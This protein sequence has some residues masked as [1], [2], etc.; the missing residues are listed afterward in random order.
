[1]LTL[2]GIILMFAAIAPSLMAGG[3]CIAAFMMGRGM[4]AWLLLTAGCMLALVVSGALALQQL[5]QEAHVQATAMQQLIASLIFAAPTW[6]VYGLGQW[7][8]KRKAG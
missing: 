2:I 8:M 6:I 5:P 7:W 3:R 4:L 1:M